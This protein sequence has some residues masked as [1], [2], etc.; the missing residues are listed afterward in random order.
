MDLSTRLS[1]LQMSEIVDVY[2]D[3]ACIG[4]GLPWPESAAG[5]G[6][7]FGPYHKLNFNWCVTDNCCDSEGNCRQGACERIQSNQRA[8]IQATESAI[9][10]AFREGIVGLRIHTDSKYVLHAITKNWIAKWKA[11]GWLNAKGKPVANQGDWI[12]LDK[13]IVKFKSHGRILEWKY[14]RAHSGNSGNDHADRL[15]KWAAED[16]YNFSQFLTASKCSECCCCCAGPDASDSERQRYAEL[17]RKML[18]SRKK[19]SL[20]S[21]MEGGKAIIL[22]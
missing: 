1:K 2:V 7:W 10:I 22:P 6:V 19:T 17:K 20:Q 21:I 13:E 12:N 3:G 11:N 15:A 18:E 14:V 9:R 4:N 5:I 16:T 8:E